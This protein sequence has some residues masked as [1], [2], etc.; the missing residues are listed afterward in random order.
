MISV[1]GFLL[2]FL[3]FQKKNHSHQI[4]NDFS[5]SQL[6][7]GAGIILH[8]EITR[9]S[10]IF[11]FNPILLREIASDRGANLVH[12]QMFTGAGRIPD[13]AMTD[14]A[15]GR[16]IVFARQTSYLQD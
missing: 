10:R 13:F 16:D 15:F 3:P 11:F 2:L 12:A 9:T 4:F 6:C 7:R 1:A 8:V 5:L 14:D